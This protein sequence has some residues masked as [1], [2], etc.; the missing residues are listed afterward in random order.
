MARV[1]LLGAALA[2]VGCSMFGGKGGKKQASA[3]LEPAKVASLAKKIREEPAKAK[4]LL[5]KAGVDRGDF[6]AALYR[7]A[8]DKEASVAY[9][10]AVR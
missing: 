10:E 9:A 3:E 4:D 8:A 1:V 5:D 6:E 7:I 2:L